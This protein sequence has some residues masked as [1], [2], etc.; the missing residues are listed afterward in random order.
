VPILRVPALAVVHSA[1]GD[2]FASQERPGGATNGV[3]YLSLPPAGPVITPEA[4][5]V[6]EGTLGNTKATL[7]AEVNPEGKAT[8]AHFEYVTE[9]HFE[10]EGFANPEETEESASLGSDFELHEAALQADLVPET[11]YRCRVIATNAD[12]P[13]GIEGQEGTFISKEALE[14]GPTTVSDVQTEAATLNAIVN[15]LGIETK[16]FFEYVEEATY[17]KD[18]EA[19]GPEHGF[20]HATKAPAGE[21]LEFGASEAFTARSLEVPGLKPATSYRFRIVATNA[22]APL[23]IK[24]PTTYLRTYGVGQEL[25]PDDRAYE[26]VSPAQKNSAEVAVPGIA[27]G[28]K[29]DRAFPIQAG[30]NS[31]EALTY[32]SWTSFGKPGSAPATSQYLSKRT[33]GG[34]QTEN[35]SPLG[36]EFNPLYPAYSGFDPELASGALKVS[37]PSLAPGCPVGFENLYLRDNTSGALRCLTPEAPAQVPSCF[38]YAGASEDQ[39]H[40]FF[41]SDGSYAGAPKSEEGGFSLYEWSAAEDKLRAVSILPGESEAVAPT[42]ATAFGP[43]GNRF[44]ALENCQVG[45]TILRHAISADG[46][47]AFWTYAPTDEAKPTQLLARINGEETIQ[48]DAKEGGGK[49]GGGVFWGASKDGSLVYFTDETKLVPGSN[50]EKGKPD[51][52][53]YEFGGSPALTD[54]SKG[55]VAGDVRGVTG[56][57]EDG[58]YVYFV[59]GA[60]LSEEANQAGLKAA[61]GKANLYV[62]H[63][64]KASFITTLAP[65]DGTDWESEPRNLSARVSPDGRHLAFLSVEAKAL[66]GYDNTVAKGQHCLL[67]QFN[68][69]AGGPLCPQAFLYDFDSG[70]L[71]CASCNP[72]GARPLGQTLFTRPTNVYEGPRYLSN[73]GQRLFFES[74]DSLL[75]A[76]ENGKRDVYEFELSGTGGCGAESPTFDPPSGGCHFLISSGRSPDHSYFVDASLDGRDVFLST[77]SA[78]NGWDTN[79]NFD[80][81]DARAGGGFP[82][83]SVEPICVGEACK[84]ATSPPPSF[85]SPPQFEGPGNQAQKPKKHKKA[86]KHL[87]HKKKSNHQ[88]RAHR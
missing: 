55:A 41:A 63:E 57:S 84:P 11:T 43:G 80:V 36:F 45:R 62:F 49:G 48:L 77:R 34:W 67:N 60:V 13:V 9:E 25:L 75:P 14:F 16:G 71:G 79:E 51:L 2:V 65:E 22:F 61:A 15:P 29:E 30:S 6:K 10:D 3:N 47:R 64:G 66:G 69:P 1:S 39:S 8:T 21:E 76:D 68:E 32:T 7:Q 20:D 12:A 28:F 52:Y 42:K 87:K 85:I 74:Y 83:P 46:S 5:K 81:Y 27:G 40:V 70:A 88:R 31:G 23:G 4:C 33:P 44:S 58:S 72:S 35:I 17:L 53:R 78:L 24:G 50:A 82:E 26:L 19:L 18:I 86:K 38:N 56:L 73:D 59:A 37:E 54:L